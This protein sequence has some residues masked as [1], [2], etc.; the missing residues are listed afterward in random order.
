MNF[1]Q[2]EIDSHKTQSI[3]CILEL[4]K[5]KFEIQKTGNF[6]KYRCNFIECTTEVEKLKL[7]VEHALKRMREVL[8][9]L[10]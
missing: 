8:C 7:S 6:Y 1:I 2:N 9:N 4:S 5:Y 3:Y 10:F